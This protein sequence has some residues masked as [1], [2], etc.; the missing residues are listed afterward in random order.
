MQILVTKHQ[1][2][3]KNVMFN[4]YT[5]FLKHSESLLT[6]LMFTPDN[7]ERHIVDT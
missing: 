4:L 2:H 5:I 6:I 3:M 7:V 1:F